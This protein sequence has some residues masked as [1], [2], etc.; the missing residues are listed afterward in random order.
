MMGK[1]NIFLQKH[2]SEDFGSLPVIVM[3][4]LLPHVLCGRSQVSLFFANVVSPGVRV[5]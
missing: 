5:E 4:S 3:P 1:N 2:V